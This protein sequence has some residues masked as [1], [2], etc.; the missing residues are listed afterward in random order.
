MKRLAIYLGM[1]A[2]LSGSAT[3]AQVS[4]TTEEEYNYGAIGY[5]IQLQTKLPVKMGYRIADYGILEE[6]GRTIAF[7]G[8]VRTGEEAPC[9]V[10]MIYTRDN[11]PPEYFCMP[12]LDA[13]PELWNRYWQSLEVI[14]DNKINQLKFMTY[15][16]SRTLMR[17]SR[18]NPSR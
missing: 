17:L 16:M 18:G 7:K 11:T 8:L 3:M 9:A 15:G 10:I 6:P 14:S 12:T 5:K 4:P 13:P 1:C 2:L